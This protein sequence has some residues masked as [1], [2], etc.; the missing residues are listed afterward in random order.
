ME[1][2]YVLINFLLLVG[3]LFLVARRLII[4]IFRGRRER[5]NM[6]LDEAELIE[7]STA[8]VFEE[9]VFDQLPF[10]ESEELLQERAEAQAKIE[11]I[12]AFGQRECNEIHR[13]MIE[14]VRKQ[15]SQLLKDEVKE[16]FSKEPYLTRLRD[17]EAQ[18]VEEIL[19]MIKL[20][21]G[22][23]SYL[24]MHKV[25]YVTLTSAHPLEYD[26]I[27]RV[28]QATRDFSVLLSLCAVAS[29]LKQFTSA[30]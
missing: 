1:I 5:I 7:N 13:N 18:R 6:Q 2:Q 26:I 12:Q 10:E 16:L 23:M 15:F 25:L 28:D 24:H 3:I 21:P 8:P 20:T 19:S 29:L 30:Q 4:K 11:Q 14:K 17:K 27:K 9:P 22:D